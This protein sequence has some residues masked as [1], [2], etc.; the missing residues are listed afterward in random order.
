MSD[1]VILDGRLLARN[2]ET[3]LIGRVQKLKERTNTVPVLATILVGDNE[4]SIAYVDMKVNACQRI[5]IEAIKVELPEFTDTEALIKKIQELNC[6]ESIHG[7]LLQHPTPKHIDEQ[8]CFDAIALNKDVDGVNTHSFGKMAM[9]QTS[10]KSASPL[11]ILN[12]LKGYNI[13]IEGKEAVIVGKSSILG[14]PIAMMLLNENA[15]ITICHSET[16]NLQEIVGRADILVAAVGKPKF[17]EASWIKPGA[18]LID[19]GYNPENIGDIDLL[20]AIPKCSA[21]TP[22]PGGVGPMT[23]ISLI[24]QTVEAAEMAKLCRCDLRSS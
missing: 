20:K 10:F 5:G 21:Y 18:V 9:N 3:D 2:I 23:I 14:K 4:A 11:A 17:I 16:K 13:K 1:Q 7:I 22:V 24:Q 6:N 19:A 12:L 15:T 8:K